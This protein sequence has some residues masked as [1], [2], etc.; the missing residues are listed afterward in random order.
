[1]PYRSVLFVLD[2]LFVLSFIKKTIKY[3]LVILKRYNPQPFRIIFYWSTI[4]T[5]PVKDG[6]TH[7]IL[8]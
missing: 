2:T 6:H 1:M 7:A 5:I 4:E 3:N 8:P